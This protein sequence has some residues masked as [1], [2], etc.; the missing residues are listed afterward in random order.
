MTALTEQAKKISDE[1]PTLTVVPDPLAQLR[2]PFPAGTIGK[3][4]RVTC[5]DC[6]A[7]DLNCSKHQKAKCNECGN[8]ISTAHIHLD[9]VGHAEVTDRL[10]SVD[11][12]WTWEPLGFDID[13]M[14][15][16]IRNGNGQAIGLWIK[17]TVAGVT[18][19]GFGSIES[20][21]FDA[22]KQLI[23]D[24]LRNA[25]MRFGV[26]LTLWSKSELESEVDMTQGGVPLDVPGQMVDQHPG[27]GNLFIHGWLLGVRS[28]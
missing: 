24:A 12:E 17:L 20:G 25:A 15:R 3:L 26:A 19:L 23:G 13:G 8:Y 6:S 7:R 4:P 5:K 2:A 28:Q 11:P 10:L 21:K 16:F 18:R 9:Y 27:F 22:E 1:T 14:P